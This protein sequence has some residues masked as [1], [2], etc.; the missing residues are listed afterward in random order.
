M[1]EN[2][3][4]EELKMMQLEEAY[5][6]GHRLVVDTLKTMYSDYKKIYL[7][8]LHNY[9]EN[10]YKHDFVEYIR[11]HSNDYDQIC[12]NINLMVPLTA[13][14]RY[15]GFIDIPDITTNS[16]L[17]AKQQGINDTLDNAYN[18]IKDTLITAIKENNEINIELANCLCQFY[19]KLVVMTKNQFPTKALNEGDKNKMNEEINKKGLSF[20]DWKQE[21]HPGWYLASRGQDEQFFDEYCD[22]LN[23]NGY[24]YDD[25]NRR[26]KDGV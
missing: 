4:N 26:E 10:S 15:L 22:Y 2:M 17:D 24:H 3:I 11:D 23:A 21:N 1:V 18:L 16:V 12:E 7:Q 20:A 13:L 25:L 14:I 6:E 9:V 8:K 19:R 5:R